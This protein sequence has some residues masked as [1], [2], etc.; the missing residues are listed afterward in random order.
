M[1]RLLQDGTFR[2][3]QDGSFRLLA[4][5]VVVAPQSSSSYS[6]GSA[7]QPIWHDLPREPKK[8]KKKPNKDEEVLLLAGML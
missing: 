5:E 3:V 8:K 2:L 4:D 7:H 6:G 1:K